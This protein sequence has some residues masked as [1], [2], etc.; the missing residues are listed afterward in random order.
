MYCVQPLYLLGQ[1]ETPCILHERGNWDTEQ[2]NDYQPTMTTQAPRSF[3]E[4]LH[5][6][7]VLTIF[8]D[9]MFFDVFGVEQNAALVGAILT[10]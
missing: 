5:E 4:G 9:F 3:I 10:E 7:G 6:R 8:K 1:H 2:G